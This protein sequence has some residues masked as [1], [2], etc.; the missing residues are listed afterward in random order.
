MLRE[1]AIRPEMLIQ[2]LFLMDTESGREPIE[3]MP[4]IERLGFGDFFEEVQRLIDSG[5]KAVA[6]FPKIDPQRKTLSGREAATDP[7]GLIPR[8]AEAVR[9]KGLPIQLIAD[10]A[11]DP[12]TTHGHDGV[13]DPVTG[14]VLNDPTVEILAEMAIVCARAGIDWVAP[15]D[16]MDGRI[17]VIRDALDDEGLSK[18]VILAYSAKFASAFYGPFRDAV[19]SAPNQGGTYLD[20]SGYQLGPGNGKEAMVEIDLDIHEGA[21]IVMV[22]P[23]GPYLDILHRVRERCEIPIAAFQ[24][25][26]E[27]AM[28][29]A[30]AEKDW[31]NYKQARDESLTAIRRAGADLILTYFAKEVAES[32]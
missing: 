12:Y 25:S 8:I 27:Y 21:D 1:T 20:K 3:S 9:D 6:L 22:K 14:E 19:G 13:V 23:A 17:G 28:I 5:I 32:L 2:P 31:L 26:G 10:I 15:S 7:H 11:L 16:M 29:H 4:R 30:A 24:V 18:T